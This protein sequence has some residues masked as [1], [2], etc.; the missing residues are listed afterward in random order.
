MQ[1]QSKKSDLLD[2]VSSLG[3]EIKDFKLLN[4]AFTHSSYLKSSPLSDA[5]SNERLEF[6]GDAVLKMYIS[7]Y[8]MSRYVGY[9]EGDLS[10]L[11]AYL[12]SEK[13]LVS[14]AKKLGLMKYILLGKNERR[15]LP[16]S[17]LA[18][19]LEAFLAVIYYECGPEKVRN[20]IFENWKECIESID[21]NLTKDNY[22]AV[23]QENLQEKQ[24]GLPV[25]EVVSE[26]GPDHNKKFEV[27]VCLNGKELARGTG[28]TKKEASQ[29]AAKNAIIFMEKGN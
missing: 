26:K 21:K 16:V 27:S 20:F 28:R 24:L 4:T 15:N 18:D 23:L 1:K 6:F 11:R 3:F 14:I 5:E 19:S 17:I 13:V 8:L 22:K 7:D 12:V 9:S 10:K 2:F 25:Y 29:V